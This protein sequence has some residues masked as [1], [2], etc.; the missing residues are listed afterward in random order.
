[1]PVGIGGDGVQKDHAD[2]VGNGCRAELSKL[3]DDGGIVLVVTH[4]SRG[5]LEI[6]LRGIGEVQ[7]L[8]TPVTSLIDGH[9]HAER[10]PQLV[11]E[12]L[13]E[14]LVMGSAL[15]HPPL[16]V[17]ELSALLKAADVGQLGSF[18]TLARRGAVETVVVPFQRE[19][20]EIVVGEAD[21]IK[22]E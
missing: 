19:I 10:A 1:M 18:G 9:I 7:R 13:G 17:S 5:R 6:E 12:Q 2:V 3:F 20:G 16:T 4:K 15:E 11:H 22:G 21:V 8:H 14:H